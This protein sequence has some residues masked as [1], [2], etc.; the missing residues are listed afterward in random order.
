LFIDWFEYE[1]NFLFSYIDIFA[2]KFYSKEAKLKLTPS[3]NPSPDMCSDDS[4][5][6]YLVKPPSNTSLFE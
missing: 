6:D 3:E 5:G 1:F 4:D 2:H